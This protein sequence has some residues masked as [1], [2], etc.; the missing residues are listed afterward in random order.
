MQ[1][2]PTLRPLSFAD[3]D[4]ADR[5]AELVERVQR[6]RLVLAG[7]TAMVRWPDEWL[8][9]TPTTPAPTPA[10]QAGECLRCPHAQCWS[11]ARGFT[12]TP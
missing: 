2:H 3:F 8:A 7:L 11:R 5:N 9:V 4:Q 6:A 12:I 1:K 10:I